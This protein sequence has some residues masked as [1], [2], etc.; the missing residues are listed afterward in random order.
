M[1]NCRIVEF[2]DQERSAPDSPLAYWHKL[3]GGRFGPGAYIKS[4]DRWLEVQFAQNYYLRAILECA[5]EVLDD[6]EDLLPLLQRVIPSLPKARAA[7][8]LWIGQIYSLYESSGRIWTDWKKIEGLE[9]LL[10]ALGGWA[11]RYGD[12]ELW[13]V[14]HGLDVLWARLDGDDRQS[15][16]M[17]WA[18]SAYADGNPFREQLHYYGTDWT[19]CCKVVEELEDGPGNWTFKYEATGWNPLF[20]GIHEFR[21]FTIAC[22]TEQLDNF[23]QEACDFAEDKGYVRSRRNQNPDHFRWTVERRIRKLDWGDIAPDTNEWETVKEAVRKIEK[24]MA[25]EPSQRTRGPKPKK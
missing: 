1:G 12:L 15:A 5:P 3:H 13:I 18:P 19:G 17:E 4:G 2:C 10:I 9:E 23:I 20:Q 8:P 11:N 22:F 25:V 6:L 14:H 24:M 16:A 21:A 7:G